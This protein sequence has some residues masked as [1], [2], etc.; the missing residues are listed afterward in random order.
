MKNEVW[1]KVERIFHTALDLSVEDRNSYLQRECAGEA[2]LLSEVESLLDCFE[3][4]VSLLDQPVFELGLEAINATRQKNLAGSVIGFY[5]LQEKIGAGGM[6]EVYKAVDMRLQRS[7][8]LK[9]LSES[10]ANDNAAKRRLIKEAQAVA[11]LEHPI[12]CTVYGIENIEEHHFIVMQFIE[13]TTLAES[14]KCRTISVEKFNSIT[15][16]IIT[17][18]AFAHSYGIIHR[19][20]K[21]GNIMLNEDGQIKILDFGLAKVI[22]EKPFLELDT[23]DTI[24]QITQNGLII[25]TVSYMSPEQLRGEKLDYRSDIFSV[26]I[27][28]YELL[29]RQNPFDRKSQ[30]ETIAAIL[31]DDPAPLKSFVPD[32][33]ER[34]I[35]LVE[36]CLHKDKE[37]RFQ[38]AAEILIELDKAETEKFIGTFSK[39]HKNYFIKTV[40]A[41][42]LLVILAVMFF[43]I[44]NRQQKTLA[45][46]PISFENPPTEKEYLADGLTQSI[47]DKLS[48]LSELKVKNQYTV[49]S[50]KG[51]TNE[52]QTAGKELN[53]DAVFAG[54][55]TKR[56]D[57]LFL[58]TKLVRTSDGVVITADEYKVEESK[59]IELQEDIS[60]RIIG[61]IKSSLTNEEKNKLSKKDTENQ[62]AKRLYILGRFHL[63]RRQGEDLKNAERYFR[64]ATNLDPSYARAWGGLADTYSLYSLP[65]HKGSISPD[66]AVKLARAAAKAALE[67]DDT[68]CEPYN[69]L[70]MIKLRYEWDWKGAEEYFRAAVSRNP[71]F[72]QAHLGLSNLLTIR[73]EFNEAIEE[74]KKAKEFSPFTVSSD[75]NMAGVYYFKRDYEQMSSVL[76]ASL[77]KFPNH[78]RLNYLRGLQLLEINKIKEATEI[79]EKMYQEDKVLAAAPLG[80]IYGKT[81]R[82][83]ET[84]KILA[85]LEEFSKKEGEDYIPSQEKAIIYLGLGELDKVF[86]NLNKACNERFPSF[87]FALNDPIFDEIKSDSRFA[88]IKNCANL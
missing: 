45:V 75:L 30:A 82:K 55:I 69:S 65:G 73:G 27:I 19:D 44:G 70:G 36:K 16:Q 77:E 29:A 12:I 47:I 56:D 25:G 68:L 8:A 37:T 38:S 84:L 15:R 87:P 51:R 81:G 52:P 1:E 64:E 4:E 40:L 79:F 24:S 23:M 63:G 54:S 53:V 13:G 43:Q 83:D 46:L 21:P 80:L 62:E 34:L 5:Q 7:V 39:R 10:L 50:F 14:I 59:L 58:V 48:N 20:L 22:Q 6:G 78:K 2:S 18:V 41:A 42:F 26:G 28:L 86:E 60:S 72:P 85:S 76:S 57:S 11:M 88:D 61:K 3:N 74:A 17:A 71:E 31:S 9:F 49:A 33:P 32:F 35:N 66:E 67:I